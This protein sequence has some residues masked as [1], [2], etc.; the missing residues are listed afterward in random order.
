MKKR[1]LGNA[2]AIF[3]KDQVAEKKK[4]YFFD[5]HPYHYQQEILDELEVERY[6]PWTYEK[7]W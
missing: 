7:S 3:D 5:I 4:Q 2:F 1:K 6:C